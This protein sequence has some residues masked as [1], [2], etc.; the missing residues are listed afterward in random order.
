ML[1][2]GVGKHKVVPR[3]GKVGLDLDG[4]TAGRLCLVQLV[5][6][7]QGFAETFD[8][9]FSIN[10]HK[11]RFQ[12]TEATVDETL[13]MMWAS[14]DQDR[15]GKVRRVVSDFLKSHLAE[16]DPAIFMEDLKLVP[17]KSGRGEM[18]ISTL[19]EIIQGAVKKKEIG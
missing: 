15:I 10:G 3:L 7:T 11:Y 13:R 14:D 9:G 18:D 17:F 16:G 2:Q 6:L 8:F 5:L 12:F 1:I 19:F 4:L